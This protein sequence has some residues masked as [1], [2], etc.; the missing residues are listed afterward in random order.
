VV[1]VL[2]LLVDVARFITGGYI[3]GGVVKHFKRSSLRSFVEQLVEDRFREDSNRLATV[4]RNIGLDG[5]RF[6]FRLPAQ[7]R[8]FVMDSA[9]IDLAQM[10]KRGE[11]DLF[12][13]AGLLSF[14]SFT[15]RPHPNTVVKSVRSDGSDSIIPVN[16]FTISRFLESDGDTG[17]LR[18]YALSRQAIARKLDVAAKKCAEIGVLLNW[19]DG[20]NFPWFRDYTKQEITSRDQYDFNT[21]TLETLLAT[22]EFRRPT[23]V[24]CE[25]LALAGFK[26]DN[27][28]RVAGRNIAECAGFPADCPTPGRTDRCCITVKRR[29]SS[30]VI[31]RDVYPSDVFQYV[32]PHEIGHYLGLCHCGHDGFQHVM[33]TAKSNSFVDP[34]LVSFYWE[35]ESHFT[36]EDGKNAWRFIVDQLTE[37]ITGEPIPIELDVS[38]EMPIIITLAD[39]CAILTNEETKNIS[40]SL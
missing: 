16:R 8:V 7:H 5:G 27:F 3:V 10:H 38:E 39:S 9:T 23:D 11:I 19:N 35:S 12:A 21:L 30:G 36:L 26:L 6:G 24:N 15:L 29:A 32:L 1:D 4:R 18:V 31:Y 33:F 13:M 28:G 20:T 25:L 40:K 37:C 14:D 34:G 17:R 22:P 2:D